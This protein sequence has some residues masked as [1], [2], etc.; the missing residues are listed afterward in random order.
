MVL[1]G[2][3]H[4]VLGDSRTVLGGFEVVL[5]SSLLSWCF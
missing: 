3:V 2:S 1:D 5:D 4:G